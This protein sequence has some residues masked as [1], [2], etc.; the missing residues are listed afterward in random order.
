LMKRVMKPAQIARAQEHIEFG[1]YLDG[2][3]QYAKA[4]NLLFGKPI[5]PQAEWDRLSDAEKGTAVMTAIAS[6]SDRQMAIFMH[7]ASCAVI[8]ELQRRS[9]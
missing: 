7:T 3:I 5:K 1:V 4:R 8:E 2:F 9:K 6:L